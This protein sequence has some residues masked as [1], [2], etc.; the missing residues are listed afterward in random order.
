VASGDY[1][2]RVDFLG[3]FSVAFNT[4]VKRLAE[5]QKEIER[6]LADLQRLATVD[7]L[8]GLDNRRSF[9]T[10]AGHEFSR[11]KRYRQQFTLM[12]FD[13]DH[14][15]RINDTHGH[16]VGDEVLR[17][18]AATCKSTLRESDIV[19]R[20]GGEEF[21][22]LFPETPPQSA[23]IPADRLRLRME[24]TVVRTRDAAVRFT[25]SGGIAEV[26]ES[27]ESIEDTLKRAD[28]ALY[29]AKQSGR[30]RIFE[31]VVV[32]GG[33]EYVQRGEE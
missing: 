5:N 2:Q 11:W 8:T 15:K 23:I 18:V 30:N 3:D 27:D 28:N 10:L 19:A 17:V 16:D 32:E 29:R 33:Y 9:L 26:V 25:I 1:S 21:V 24:S 4:M 7:S 6:Q 13:L 20:I 12:M 31:P 14:F 22:V